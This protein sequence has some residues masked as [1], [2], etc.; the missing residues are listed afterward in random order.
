MR[1]YKWI[2]PEGHFGMVYKEGLNTDIMPFNPKGDCQAGGLYYARE[3]IL[4]FW[5]SG[6]DL[7]EVTPVGDEVY[8]NP[9]YPKKWKAHAVN[10][11]YIGKRS[12][13]KII[14]MLLDNGANVHANNDNALISAVEEGHTEIVKL[15]LAAGGNVHACVD[16]PL[17]SA[18]VLGHTEI[19]KLLLEAGADVHA[20]NDTPLI[21]A[22]RAGHTEIVKLLLEAGADV[23]ADAENPLRS[24]AEEGHTEI[25]KLLLDAGALEAGANAHAYENPLRSAARKG[26][27]EIVKLFLEAGADVRAYDDAALR[28]AA[29]SGHLE[30]VKLLLKKDTSINAN[31]AQGTALLAAIQY[32]DRAVEVVRFLLKQGADIHIDKNK[33]LEQAVFAE[34]PKTLKLL[35]KYGV[36]V[37]ANNDA[38]LITAAGYGDCKSVKIL[39]AAGADALAQDGAALKAATTAPRVTKLLKKAIQ[40]AQNK[41]E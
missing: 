11:K 31:R 26:H 1:F 21:S 39:L 30:I 16:N 41:K 6:E 18:A 8:K 24:A 37:H 35:F 23:H 7:Y 36:D 13:P 25:V 40:E 14:Q 15:L 19:V 28:E 5:D 12:D 2:K 32:R 17:R 10:L 27:L 38:A 34:S 9:G 29:G 22:A 33:L 4:A 3:D 20:N